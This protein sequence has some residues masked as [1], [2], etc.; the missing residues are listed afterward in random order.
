MSIREQIDR[1]RVKH[2]VS[3][4]QLAGQ[5]EVQFVPCL[6]ALLHSYPLPLIELALV[7]TLVDGW[8]AVPLV[9]GLAFLKQV[10]DKLKGWDAG[11][12]AS[13]ITPAQFQQIT[14]LDPSPIFGAPTA[15]ARSS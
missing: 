4:Y 3:S 8:A 10:H 9:R 5:D 7:E 13:T 11:S 15:I 12:I 2:I 1:Q 14:G 6:D